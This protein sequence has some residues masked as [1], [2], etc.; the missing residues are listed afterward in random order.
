MFTNSVQ[1]VCGDV[2]AFG[3][4]VYVVH[5]MENDELTLLRVESQS[6]ARHRAD[7]MPEHWSDMA[8]SGLPMQD[9][10]IRCV[11]IKRY[12][13]ANLTRLGVMPDAVK[14]R[15]AIACK[16]EQQVR[17]FEDGPSVQSNLMA[18]T[19]SRGRRIGAV[20]YA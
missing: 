8:L 19:S 17:R 6:D 7:I 4:S 5:E 13:T 18:C 2:V 20:R 3:A 1:I 16:R 11:P 12:G 9:V 10:V 15:I 14:A